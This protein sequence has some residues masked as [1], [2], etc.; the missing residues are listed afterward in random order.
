MLDT[1]IHRWLRVPYTLHVDYVRSPKKASATVLFLHG[2]GSTGA[3]WDDVIK[4]MPGDIQIITI[5]LL[6]FGKSPRPKWPV[7]SA[8]TQARAVLA[9]LFKMRVRRRLI[10]VGHSLGALVAVEMAR[11]YPLLIKSM[12]LCSPPFY[13][14]TDTTK[15][16]LPSND[17]TLRR[18]YRLAMNKPDQFL[19][20]SAVAMKY[21]LINKSFNV[22]SENIDSYMNTLESMVINQTSYVDA[23]HLNVPTLILRGTLDP[24]VVGKNIRSITKSN[25]LVSSRTVVAS[26]EVKGL[27][28]SA[29]VKA[30]K[31]QLHQQK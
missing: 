24:L 10:V 21:N 6:G 7:Y 16:F 9:T 23:L 4:E 28:V 22:T 20:M 11:R 19:Q 13:D 17:Q 1:L 26:H 12:V 29:T 15:R 5:D 3:A 2:I 31:Q 18:I 27:F 8:K 14:V 25:P 30:V